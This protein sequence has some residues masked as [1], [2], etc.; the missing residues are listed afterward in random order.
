MS[1][2]NNNRVFW[3]VQAFGMTED[4]GTSFTPVHGLQSVGITTTFNLDQIFE[5]GESAIYENVED[6]PDVEVT[7]EK[8][9]DGYPLIY[10]LATPNATSATLIG[11][12]N[13]KCTATLSIFS[14]D[15]DS[16][17]GTPNAQ[18]TMSG[19]YVSNLS[20]TIPNDGSATEAVTL[21]GNNK[22]WA[23][24]SF[25]FSGSIFDNTDEPLALTSGTGGVQR[26]ENF[27][28]GSLTDGTNSL[29]PG[30]AGG[31]PGINSD[32]TNDLRADGRGYNAAVNNIS[33]SADF[34]REGLNQLGLRNPFFR[35]V[36]LPVEVTIDIEILSKDGDLIDATEEG[37]AGNGDNLYAQT[38][39]VVMEDS[40]KIDLGSQNKLSNVSYGG[41][42][43]GGGNATNTFSYVTYNTMTV[44][45]N[46]D[47][48][49]L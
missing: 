17:S 21:V 38:I 45:Q 18:V 39:L 30:G 23:T 36:N 28:Y 32:G 10:H 14:D 4:G 9:L 20:Y 8:V 11:R 26:R 16:A 7:L 40:T 27:V 46:Q 6:T 1:L 44:T 42:D 12:S 5:I 13:E 3:A 49:G 33:I 31:I 48:A 41:A 25:T 2:N 15:L 19:M 22:V 34:G 47:P 37:A 24:G 43:A 35:F 29:L